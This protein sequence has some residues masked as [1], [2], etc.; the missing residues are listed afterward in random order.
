MGAFFAA[1]LLGNALAPIVGGWVSHYA[2]WRYLQLGLFAFGGVLCLA[3][4]LYLPET[5]HPGTTGLEKLVHAELKGRDSE[6]PTDS[7]TAPIAERP[8]FRWVWLNPLACLWFLRSPTIVLTARS[9]FPS[10]APS[11]S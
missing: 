5:S 11:P 6:E 4:F 9:F 8:A 3:M 2:S 10:H 1:A 7:E